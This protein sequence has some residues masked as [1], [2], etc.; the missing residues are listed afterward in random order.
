M[1][2][3]FHL[4]TDLYFEQQRANAIRSVLPFVTSRA[5]VRRGSRVLEIGCGAGGV[6]KAFAE[7]GAE[8]V[9]V[10]LDA[11]SIDYARERFARDAPQP[12]WRF[13]NQDIYDV[14]PSALGGPFHLVVLKDTIEHIHDQ[15]ALLS[16]LSRFLVDDGRVFLAFPPWHMPFG[17]HQQ[18]CTHR[19]LMRLPYFH[20]LPPRAYA[21]ILRRFGEPP[22]IIDALLEI[23]QTGISI[24]RFERVATETGHRVLSRRLYLVNPMYQDRYGLAPREQLP[25]FARVPGV[26]DL[27]TTSAYYLLA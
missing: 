9:G 13:E 19:I 12:Q 8:V 26:R 15:R 1:P 3:D 4:D 16:R 11:P 6:L 18:I 22:E 27:V 14:D 5:V 7:L 2:R 17:G 21:A 24:E 10:D 25:A 20:L 23:K